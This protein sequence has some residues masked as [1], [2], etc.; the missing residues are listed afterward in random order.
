MIPSLGCAGGSCGKFKKPQ[1]PEPHP[2]E[3]DLIGLG[4]VQESVD[5]NVQLGLRFCSKGSS[6][7]LGDV[8]TILTPFSLQTAFTR[9]L[10]L[11]TVQCL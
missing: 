6:A 5:F 8:T 9:M 4:G 2:G 7:A 10:P 1:P 11:D 3:S